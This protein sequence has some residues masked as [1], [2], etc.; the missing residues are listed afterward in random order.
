MHKIH[1]VVRNSPAYKS[2]I[3]KGDYLISVNNNEIKDIL[4]YLYLTSDD[5][6]SFQIMAADG[7]EK[8][9]KVKN[10]YNNPLGIEFEN[11][12]I[13]E[14]KSCRNKCVFCFIDQLPQNMRASL[15]FKDDD[16]RLCFLFG[17]YIT[18][19]N[20]DMKD[21]NR[22]VKLRLSPVN[23]SVHTTNPELR[24]KMLNNKTA[25]DILDKI[26][27]L[28]ENEIEMHVQ[29]V[30]CPGVNDGEELKCT[31]KDLTRFY[32]FVQSVSI[33]DVGLTKYRDNLYPLKPVDCAKA[34]EI[35]DIASVFQKIMY[36]KY[37]TRW[38]YCS[39]EIYIKSKRRIPEYDFYEEFLQFQNGVGFIAAFDKEFTDELNNCPAINSYNMHIS[40]ACGASIA[41]YIKNWCSLAEKKY[42]IKIDV[43]EVI[44]NFFGNSITASGLLTGADIISALKNKSLGK[45]LLL[46]N[47]LLKSGTD[48]LLD[49]ISIADIEKQLNVKI[50]TVPQDGAEFLKIILNLN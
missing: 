45:R 19:T 48:L 6:L 9:I 23:I 10:C 44:N 29:I 27:Y 22:I 37:N 8:S 28:H 11:P 34:N 5:K 42:G 32:P 7:K 35:I 3:K 12:T 17:N 38:V 41:P 21:L 16:Y 50:Q 47:T 20:A 26:R 40:V 33:V 18:L 30:L 49:D 15:Y 25:G 43:Y 24:I 1:D 2:G 39:D 13:D 4:D 36:K 31:L 46:P 14:M